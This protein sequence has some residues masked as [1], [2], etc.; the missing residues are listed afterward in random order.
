MSMNF[1]H[2]LR[3]ISAF[4]IVASGFSN[5]ADAQNSQQ[6][7]SYYQTI[8]IDGVLKTKPALITVSPKYQVTIVVKG[9]EIT[10]VSLELSKQ[11][12]FSV[13]L[14]DNH[15]MI[16]LDTLTNK[17]GADLNLILDDE[18]VLPVHLMVKDSPTGTRIFTFESSDGTDEADV[19]AAPAVAPSPTPLAPAPAPVAPAAPPSGSA[20]PSTPPAA[21][22]QTA[23][24]VQRTPA[25][26]VVTTRPPTLAAPPAAKMDVKV[27]R[28]G[29]TA[30]VNVRLAATNDQAIRAELRN[31]RLYDGWKSVPYTVVAEPKGRLLPVE[32]TVKVQN[33]PGNLTV[34]WPVSNVVSRV[35]ATLKSQIKVN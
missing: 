11:K 1:S 30:N 35:Q 34:M 14:A 19:S 24:T 6:N 27:V 3:V 17:G 18:Q 21:V 32:V 4:L 13:T 12:L 8:S 33:V 25:A 7:P 2:N 5:F 29:T 31:L 28:S 22:K 16:F 23:P 9:R 20:K 10:G 26:P 15:R